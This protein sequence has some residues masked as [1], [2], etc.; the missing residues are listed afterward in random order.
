MEM[1]RFFLI[2]VEYWRSCRSITRRTLQTNMETDRLEMDSVSDRSVVLSSS[3]QSSYSLS[4]ILRA[5]VARL[6]YPIHLM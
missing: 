6:L 1:Y 2:G 5:P 4:P 3:R